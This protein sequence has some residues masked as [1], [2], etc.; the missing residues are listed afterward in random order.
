M[1]YT[2][3]SGNFFTLLAA[4]VSA[5]TKLSAIQAFAINF[6]ASTAQAL[7]RGASFGDALKGGL[8]SGASA[9][10]FVG[11]GNAFSGAEGFWSNAYAQQA[12]FGVTGGLTNLLQG[13]KFGH[14]F[15]SASL[16]GPLSGGAGN[17]L[18]RVI[19]R[20]AGRIIASSIVGGSISAA[21]GGKFGN[22][23]T[24]AAL[25]IAVQ[26][27]LTVARERFAHPVSLEIPDAAPPELNESTLTVD[28]PLVE[29]DVSAWL[30]APPEVQSL[31]VPSASSAEIDFSATTAGSGHTHGS[32]G[33]AS[34][35]VGI[36]EREYRQD[37]LSA[38]KSIGDLLVAGAKGPV[39][40]GGAVQTA[41]FLRYFGT[42]PRP[43]RREVVLT[44]GLNIARLA[45]SE[46][47]API[48]LAGRNA[49]R[50][51]ISRAP[52][53]GHARTPSGQTVNP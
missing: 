29:V 11:L 44:V 5:F 13:G 2:D 38:L 43:V 1:S 7:V 4:A 40:V 3:P 8:I 53:A 45:M 16:S 46:G 48:G 20:D 50:G 15:A 12:A 41:R 23:T 42:L 22:G 27:G 31:Q 49:A 39:Y 9:A 37:N 25:T 52:A 32:A 34:L 47:Q 30:S 14:G 28:E 10:A 35:R 17:A 21:T 18:G 36:T 19:G 24:Y 26:G 33:A 51:T 6:V